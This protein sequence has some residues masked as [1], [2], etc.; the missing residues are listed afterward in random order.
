MKGSNESLQKGITN[1]IIQRCKT[2]NID[3][4]DLEETLIIKI[5]KEKR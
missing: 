3:L 5:E 4:E 2:T 1:E